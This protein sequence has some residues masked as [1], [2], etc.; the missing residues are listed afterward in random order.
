[1]SR[2]DYEAIRRAKTEAR[3]ETDPVRAQ[4]ILDAAL[5]PAQAEPALDRPVPK[6][7]ARKAPAKRKAKK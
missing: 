6:P 3:A 4:A 7:K 1:M 2:P 5:N